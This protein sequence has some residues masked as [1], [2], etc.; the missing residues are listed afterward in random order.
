MLCVFAS[1]V[2][3]ILNFYKFWRSFQIRNNKLT[4]NKTKQITFSFCVQ[5]PFPLGGKQA[6]RE[7]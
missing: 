6:Q 2:G 3:Q 1:L 7:K 4:E 5:E